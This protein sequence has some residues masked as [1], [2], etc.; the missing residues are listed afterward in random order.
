MDESGQRGAETLDELISKS[1]IGSV[2]NDYALGMDLR[3]RA[4]FLSAWHDDAT[5]EVNSAVGGGPLSATGH[6]EIEAALD[7]LWAMEQLVLHLTGNHEIQL[8]SPTR[9]HADCHTVIIGVTQDGKFFL[10]GAV[11]PEDKFELRDGVWRFSYRRVEINV[12][13]EMD[14]RAAATHLFLGAGG[15]FGPST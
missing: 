2:L 14:E 4:R 6:A 8:D 7:E 10:N 3:N 12:Y 11:Y 1:R 5:W 13:V 9:A 15:A